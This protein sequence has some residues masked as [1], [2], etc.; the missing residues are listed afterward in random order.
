VHWTLLMTQ[1]SRNLS[2]SYTR[3]KIIKNI[4]TEGLVTLSQTY[5]L[6]YVRRWY[7]CSSVI[8]KINTF[9]SLFCV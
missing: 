2:Y 3:S 5:K 8:T 4:N 1:E 9:R 7:I 6:H